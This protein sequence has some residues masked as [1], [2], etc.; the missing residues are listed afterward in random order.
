MHEIQALIVSKNASASITRTW[1]EAV[2]RE[3]TPTLVIV[4]L[5]ASLVH[6]M[7]ARQMHFPDLEDL[8]EVRTLA[9]TLEPVI[10]ALAKLGQVGP[11]A[12]V[13]TQYWGGAGE[14][15]ALLLENGAVRSGPLVGPGS[16][17][18]ILGDL[19]VHQDEETG[20]DQFDVVGLGRWRSTEDIIKDTGQR[21]AAAD[22]AAR[23]SR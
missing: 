9:V 19:G 6:Q 1:S 21:G 11:L 7:T 15:A 3:L 16:I 18:T 4:P 2:Q 12:L 22:G 23:R 17:N 14:Q 5:G 10:E 20:Y 8:D 13:L